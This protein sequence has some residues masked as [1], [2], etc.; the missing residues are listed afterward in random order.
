MY[1]FSL[2]T[3]KVSDFKA[4]DI[5]WNAVKTEW[6]REIESNYDSSNEEK[7]GWAMHI[8]AKET[9]NKRFS[10]IQKTF[11]KHKFMKTKKWEMAFPQTKTS[12][13]RQSCLYLSTEMRELSITE[14][15]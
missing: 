5:N 9:F 14:K 1:I 12:K 13:P 3:E 2:P 7:K 4:W 10:F 11:Q 15:S 6:K 8:L